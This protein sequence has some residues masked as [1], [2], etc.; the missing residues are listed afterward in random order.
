MHS[1]DVW[2]KAK[3]LRKVLVKVGKLKGMELIALWA[4]EI[5]K[6][7]W[8]CCQASDRDVAVLKVRTVQTFLKHTASSCILYIATHTI[9]HVVVKLWAYSLLYQES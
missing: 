5:Y 8:Y 3:K 4:D 6:H 1:L 7:S 9:T 2:H